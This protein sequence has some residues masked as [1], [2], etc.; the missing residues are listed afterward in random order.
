MSRASASVSRVTWRA[1]REPGVRV[2]AGLGTEALH[3]LARVDR[4]GR[5]GAEDAHLLGPAADVDDDRV[6]V[7]RVLDGCVVSRRDTPAGPP[8]P[9]G[10]PEQGDGERRAHGSGKSHARTVSTGCATVAGAGR[11][12]MLDYTPTTTPATTT[13]VREGGSSAFPRVRERRHARAGLH[14]GAL[15][16]SKAAA[17]QANFAE[18]PL[19]A[20][21]SK[22]ELKLLA[23][24][25][26]VEPRAAG[27]TLVTEG[28]SGTNAFVILQGKCKVTSATDAG[29]GRSRAAV[30]SASSRCSTGRPAT[31]PSSR[32]RRSRWRCS[33]AASS[34]R[35][36]TARRRSAAS[37]SRPSPP[38]C[39]SSTPARRRQAVTGR[40]GGDRG[41]RRDSSAAR[42]ARSR[43]RS[44]TSSGTG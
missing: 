18:V 20:N 22:R 14:A 42:S 28:E 44:S 3:G 24:T 8:T 11:P 15:R 1:G 6:A 21:C 7:D 10:A 13:P 41:W 25:A 27:A 36:S 9:P 23:K 37:S 32:R 33:G 35:C 2:R 40:C 16:P 5:V 19:F 30:S 4:L 38:A 34:S 12:G 26:V 17:V 39:R 29:S 31:R 43:A